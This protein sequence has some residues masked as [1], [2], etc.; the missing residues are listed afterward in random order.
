ML[1]NNITFL[2]FLRIPARRCS[3]ADGVRTDEMAAIARDACMTRDMAHVNVAAIV[4]TCM[5]ASQQQQSTSTP[6]ML[7]YAID[8]T[9]CHNLKL[10]LQRCRIADVSMTFTGE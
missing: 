10:F 7:L 8:A 6:S 9:D 1:L 3:V 4:A 5:T 2:S